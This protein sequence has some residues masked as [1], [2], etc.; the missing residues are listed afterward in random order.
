MKK[1]L[2]SILLAGV[3]TATFAQKSE[4]A[5]AKKAWGIYQLTGATGADVSKKM[6]TLNAAIKHTDAAI[7]HEK[8][9]NLPDAWSY[10]ALLTSAAAMADT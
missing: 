2:L 8:S 5:E 4:I 9:K 10:R 1:V 6:E 7:A 3:G